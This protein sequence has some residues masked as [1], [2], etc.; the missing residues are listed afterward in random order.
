MA[1]RTRSRRGGASAPAPDRSDADTD[2][3]RAATEAAL[4]RFERHLEARGERT[5]RVDRHLERMISFGIDFAVEEIGLTPMEANA[6]MVEVYMGVAHP[7]L[8][9]GETIGSVAAMLDTLGR[10][11]DF[12]VSEGACPPD[13]LEAVRAVLAQRRR[14]EERFRTYA[15]LVMKGGLA[16]GVVGDWAHE[17]DDDEPL[18]LP[19]DSFTRRDLCPLPTAPRR[20]LPLLREHGVADLPVLRDLRTLVEAVGER[21]LPLTEGNAW[22]TRRDLAAINAARAAPERMERRAD[23]YDL[24]VLHSLATLARYLHVLQ[25]DERR[26]LLPG[27]ARSAFLSL[28]PEEQ[29][30]T[31]L[32]TYWNCLNWEELDHPGSGWL[33]A[34]A[35]RMR[36]KLAGLILTEA[37]D[38]ETARSMAHAAVMMAISGVVVANVV[39]TLTAF[40]LLEEGG[41]DARALDDELRF[42][43]PTP[44]GRAVL[45]GLSKGPFLEGRGG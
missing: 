27:P 39:P 7:E 20:L 5:V 23:Q 33:P 6:R 17:L 24:P 35:Q 16:A 3:M 38:P 13:R 43:R 34:R 45:G 36:D 8:H 40:G 31:L 30:W 19:P 12:L 10:W 37:S 21:G 15:S 18:T 25:E 4:Y 44:L 28:P 22:L 9:N 32:D 29:Y 11:S 26:R 1:K 14:F 41:P 2:R 42:P